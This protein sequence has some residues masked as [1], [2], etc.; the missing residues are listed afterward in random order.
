MK[1]EITIEEAIEELKDAYQEA[2]ENDNI[3]NPVA[4]ALLQVLR[5]AET[6]GSKNW[7]NKNK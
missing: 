6:R 1:T 4:N 2:Y 5:I 7:K 3:D